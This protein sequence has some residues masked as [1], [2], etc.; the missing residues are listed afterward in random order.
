[1]KNQ[2]HWGSCEAKKI[3]GKNKFNRKVVKIK[4]A[5]VRLKIVTYQYIRD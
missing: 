3:G 2:G 1:M 5:A 4:K